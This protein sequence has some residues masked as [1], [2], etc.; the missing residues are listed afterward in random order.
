[1]GHL[2]ITIEQ[3]VEALPRHYQY[4]KD[5]GEPVTPEAARRR[6]YAAALSA[7]CRLQT[8]KNMLP[9]VPLDRPL[10]YDEAVRLTRSFPYPNQVGQRLYK[11]SHELHRQPDLLVPRQDTKAWR[12]ELTRLPGLGLCKASFAVCLCAPL[13]SQVVC[14]DRWVLQGL[15]GRRMSAQE[16]H[17][18]FDSEARYL[19]AESEIRALSHTLCCPPFVV[20]WAIWD[21]ARGSEESHEFVR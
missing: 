5:L 19:E 4:A 10:T 3:L 13:R 17:R 7:A 15:V 1:M 14:I 2:P 6:I 12:D 16:I 8:V 11:L 18:S 9:H 21:I 20:Q